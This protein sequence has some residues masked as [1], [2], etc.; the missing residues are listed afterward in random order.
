VIPFAA[1]SR[2]VEAQVVVRRRGEAQASE[3]AS[4]G[5]E[6]EAVTAVGATA[7]EAA[8]DA[9]WSH[10]R[11]PSAEGGK[12]GH[13]LRIKPGCRQSAEEENAEQLVDGGRCIRDRNL[14][15]VKGFRL[16]AARVCGRCAT[17]V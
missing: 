10:G 7:A 15:V 14:R 17:I 11:L 8:S 5:V 6:R 12:L 1:T 2:I 3:L 16:T 4:L 9:D 13:L